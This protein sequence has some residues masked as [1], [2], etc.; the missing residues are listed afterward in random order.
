MAA[1]M[2]SSHDTD[3][4]RIADTRHNSMEDLASKPN[5]LETL[6]SANPQQTGNKEYGESQGTI[7][8]SAG[9]SNPDL[10]AD[11]DLE[12]GNANAEKQHEK[13]IEAADPNIVGWDGDD[14][15]DK[16]LNWPARKR[17]LI[18]VTLGFVTLCITFAS[19][20]FSTG[21]VAVAK[22]FNVSTE[23]TTLGTS[24]FVLGFA[25]GP[26]VFGPMSE[27]FGRKKP[28]FFGFFVFA[29]F[30]VAT[31]VSQTLY[32]IMIT[33]FFGGVFGSSPLAIVG[34]T[35]ADMWGPVDRGVAVCVFAA[36]TFVGPVLGKNPSFHKLFLLGDG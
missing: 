22:Q 15:P 34:G 7:A 17:W 9:S 31:A 25:V 24:L 36:A 4:T 30:Q 1:T 8:D 35:L 29:I 33:R 20:V 13:P 6:H 21:T 2:R 26:L 27:L 18:T 16:P 14:D 5:R 28:L 12:A 10:G 23:V 3:R 19:S 11:K 32:S